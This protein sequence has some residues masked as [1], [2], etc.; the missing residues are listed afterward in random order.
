M[1]TFIMATDENLFVNGQ[2]LN[3]KNP[4]M[5]DVNTFGTTNI[6]FIYLA[7]TH[8]MTSGVEMAAWAI[9]VDIMYCKKRPNEAVIH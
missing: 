5:K 1:P 8:D 9:V 2:L 4:E 7:K 3:R 6:Y